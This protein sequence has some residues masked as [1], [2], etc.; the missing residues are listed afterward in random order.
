M[1]ASW[2][3]SMSD[4][5]SV[6]GM[7]N[8]SGSVP[9]ASIAVNVG[10]VQS[11]SWATMSMSGLASSN[12]ATWASN[13]WNAVLRVARPKADDVEDELV[14]CAGGAAE[15]RGQHARGRWSTAS[16]DH[17]APRPTC[18]VWSFA[19]LLTLRLR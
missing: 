13:A 2:P 16:G 14:L 3:C 9:P 12:W 5:P 11:Y 8:T 18:C 10:P 15:A 4:L 1:S 7:V 6:N 17:R 19:D